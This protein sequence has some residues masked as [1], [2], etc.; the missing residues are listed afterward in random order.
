MKSMYLAFLAT[1]LITVAA[2]V[3]LDQIGYSAAEQT[4]SA[5]NV[6]LE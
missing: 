5:G 6:R 2:D 4:S 1:I 3:G